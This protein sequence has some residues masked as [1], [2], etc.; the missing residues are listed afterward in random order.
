MFFFCYKEASNRSIWRKTHMAGNYHLPAAFFFFSKTSATNHQRP[1]VKENIKC[2]SRE[3]NFN[4]ISFTEGWVA[5]PNWTVIV[6][7]TNTQRLPMKG[8][9]PCTARALK[10]A[11]SDA[12]VCWPSWGLCWR[13]LTVLPERDTPEQQSWPAD[14]SLILLKDTG[15]RATPRD[16]KVHFFLSF[17]ITK[18][19]K[20][21][22]NNRNRKH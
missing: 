12:S 20:T 14:N 1:L 11:S 13:A 15:W 17:H 19:I 22:Q 5:L 2:T 4:N 6:G 18:K 3:I 7:G 8:R 16:G 21:K 10:S 9:R